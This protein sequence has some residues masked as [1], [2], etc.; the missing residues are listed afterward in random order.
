MVVCSTTVLGWCYCRIR[1][2]A[3]AVVAA[4]VAAVVDVAVELAFAS[5]C[6]TKCNVLSLH[7]LI[8]LSVFLSLHFSPSVSS[9]APVAAHN[10]LLRPFAVRCV[11]PSLIRI[12]HALLHHVMCLFDTS[13]F[14]LN[15]SVSPSLFF[16]K[17]F[18]C[19]LFHTCLSWAS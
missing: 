10:V 19:A 7:F 8:S 15:S 2:A 6:S 1:V 9:T 18:Y 16:S 14:S 11:G 13:M 5:K 17:N 4:A 12:H 3:A